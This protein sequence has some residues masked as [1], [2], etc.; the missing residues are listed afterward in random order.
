MTYKDAILDVCTVFENELK[1]HINKIRLIRELLMDSTADFEGMVGEPE[2]SIMAG[3]HDILSEITRAYDK[4]YAQIEKMEMN[5]KTERQKR[6]EELER[7]KAALIKKMAAETPSQTAQR[8][9]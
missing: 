7:E 4:S 5:T 9:F 3:L 8:H 6:L 1:P 2:G